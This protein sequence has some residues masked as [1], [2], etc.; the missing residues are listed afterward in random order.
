ME[1]TPQ[2]AEAKRITEQVAAG[3][4]S[5]YSAPTT[6]LSRIA[7]GIYGAEISDIAPVGP[8]S[9]EEL[10]RVTQSLGVGPGQRF[11][12]LGCG[13]GGPA[14]WLARETGAD[15]VGVDIVPEA[16]AKARERA[17]TMGLDERVNFQVADVTATGLPTNA[18]EGSVSI[19][20]LLFVPD[21]EGALREAARIVRPGG[22]S[23][24]LTW[25]S[26]LPFPG[27]AAAP[28]SDYRPLL[29]DA[30][31]EIDAHDV[32]PDR[33]PEHRAFAEALLAAEREL[34][35]EMGEEAGGRE[36][37]IARRTVEGGY[38]PRRRVLIVCRGD[39][40]G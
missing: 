28:V 26:E 2:A 22:R 15:A 23:I 39:N 21:K 29:R 32:M 38:P 16:I 11:V 5:T 33:S 12:D 34:I 7:R 24:L 17:R 9:M 20:T 10:H 37:R 14:L 25:E 18:F 13:P 40:D 1:S 27:I 6:T 35:E 30:G 4:A 8:L 31:L 3:Y 36:L 19:N